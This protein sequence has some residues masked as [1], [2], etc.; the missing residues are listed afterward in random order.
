MINLV[1][2]TVKNLNAFLDGYETFQNGGGQSSGFGN[3]QGSG[4]L[5]SGGFNQAGF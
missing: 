2:D 5:L 1:T 3:D 4:D